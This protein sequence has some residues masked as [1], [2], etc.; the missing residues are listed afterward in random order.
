MHPFKFVFPHRLTR[1]TACITSA[2]STAQAR[3][4]RRPPATRHLAAPALRPTTPAAGP[5][6]AG[7]PAPASSRAR[8]AGAR[9]RRRRVAAAYERIDCLVELNDVYAQLCLAETH[10]PYDVAFPLAEVFMHVDSSCRIRS[11]TATEGDARE[12]VW[13]YCAP[14]QNRRLSLG[15]RGQLR[16]AKSVAR[17]SRSART[18]QQPRHRLLASAAAAHCWALSSDSSATCSSASSKKMGSGSS[19]SVGGKKS[20]VG[21]SFCPCFG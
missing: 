7:V 10:P 13:G 16:K 21:F 14:G 15:E 3:Q 12:A 1:P 5:E 11:A 2:D 18:A 4:A 17:G 6:A 20:A 8:A 9:V 19:S